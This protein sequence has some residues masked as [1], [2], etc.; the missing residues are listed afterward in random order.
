MNPYNLKL[1][2]WCPGLILR[3]YECFLEITHG[4]LN[5]YCQKL[6]SPS[7][8]VFS[9]LIRGMLGCHF[10]Q[11]LVPI[12]SGKGLWTL[13]LW[14]LA[15]FLDNITFKWPNIVHHLRWSAHLVE[16]YSWQSCF[17]DWCGQPFPTFNQTGLLLTRGI[18]PMAEPSPKLR[19]RI[20][21][22]RKVLFRIPIELSKRL[23]RIKISY[24]ST[25]WILGSRSILAHHMLWVDF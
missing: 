1:L 11:A 15:C 6:H 8:H 21:D 25:H 2:F 18:P 20:G 10:A 3:Y 17:C 9:N 19:K 23:G 16:Q 12:A 24:I 4:F 5:P 22:I 13:S 7:C 14:E